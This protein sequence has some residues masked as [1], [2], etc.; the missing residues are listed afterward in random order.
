MDE[1]KLQI[2][3]RRAQRAA[4][5][6]AFHADEER[7]R[8]ARDLDYMKE[9]SDKRRALHHAAR[10]EKQAQ[11]R[12]SIMSRTAD[13][14]VEQA[15]N[16]FVTGDYATL[17]QL[18]RAKKGFEEMWGEE[19]QESSAPTD[20][21]QRL[22]ILKQMLAKAKSENASAEFRLKLHEEIDAVE[23]EIDASNAGGE[24]P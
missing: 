23:D 9:A 20:L 22:A 2:H 19:T 16:A 6:A 10:E 13:M 7:T 8:M 11:V 1:E 12:R 15:L 3:L 24:I 21:E 5:I 17:H 14:Q 18:M 4:S